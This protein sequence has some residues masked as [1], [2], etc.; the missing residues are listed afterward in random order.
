MNGLLPNRVT[1]IYS[2]QLK[3]NRHFEIVSMNTNLF[4]HEINLEKTVLKMLSKLFIL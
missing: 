4:T 2:H 1:V 3:R